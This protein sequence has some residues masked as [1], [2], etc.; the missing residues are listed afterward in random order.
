MDHSLWEANRF[1]ATQEILRILRNPKAHYRI[2]QRPPPVPILSQINPV[3][4]PTYHFLKIHLKLS[5][6]SHTE[7]YD[8]RFTSTYRVCSL[9]RAPLSWM[10]YGI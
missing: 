9:Y 3:H 10:L 5:N 4:A 2:H 1:A 8:A 7:K 6:K